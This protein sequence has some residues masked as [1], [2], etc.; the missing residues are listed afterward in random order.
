LHRG[1]IGENE[2]LGEREM[3]ELFQIAN[4]AAINDADWAEI[5][6]LRA[7]FETGGQE[8][9]QKAY[10]ELGR[11]PVQYIR[12][13]SAIYPDEVQA[14]IKDAV[15]KRGLT[16]QDILDAVRKRKSPVRDQ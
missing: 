4:P 16:K 14:S 12:V 11:H 5:N 9:L 2:R 3:N 10:R 8:A 13:M 15:A 6:K 1:R 7:A